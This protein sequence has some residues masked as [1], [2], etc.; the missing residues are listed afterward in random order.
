[1]MMT[2]MTMRRMRMRMRMRMMMMLLM[3]MPMMMMVMVMMMVKVVN[4]LMNLLGTSLVPK[5]FVRRSQDRCN[6]LILAL[7]YL[8]I[9]K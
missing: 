4:K 8:Y 2:R 6:L 1:M 3:I 5:G 9:T 7:P